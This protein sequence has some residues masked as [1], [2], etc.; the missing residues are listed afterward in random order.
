[1]LVVLVLLVP[2]DSKNMHISGLG[3][4][5]SLILGTVTVLLLRPWPPAKTGTL[6]QFVTG[7]VHYQ[8]SACFNGFA[9][10]LNVFVHLRTIIGHRHI[11]CTYGEVHRVAAS[12]AGVTTMPSRRAIFFVTSLASLSLMGENNEVEIPSEQGTTKS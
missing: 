7:V 3:R 10:L 9:A 6:C 2:N 4:D 11:P 1:V 5:I 8:T 12:H